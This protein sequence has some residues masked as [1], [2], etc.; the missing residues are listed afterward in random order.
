M[1][2]ERY[3]SRDAKE[4]FKRKNKCMETSV[5]LVKVKA[6]WIQSGFRSL[7]LGTVR[8]LQVIAY[9]EKLCVD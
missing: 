5:E 3:V 6:R 8:Y 7:P 2:D 1:D 9:D 4:H